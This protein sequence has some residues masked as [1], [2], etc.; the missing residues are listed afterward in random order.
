MFKN[1][2]QKIDFNKYM[3]HFMCATKKE[4][5]KLDSSFV[6]ETSLHLTPTE[7]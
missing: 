6:I 1:I 3:T 4:H 7:G 5:A 2:L